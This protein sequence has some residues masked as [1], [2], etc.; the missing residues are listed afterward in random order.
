MA[1]YLQMLDE[2]TRGSRVGYELSLIL[3][4]LDE[5][6]QHEVLMDGKSLFILS[7]G[8]MRPVIYS[9]HI[10]D[11]LINVAAKSVQHHVNYMSPNE[12]LVGWLE[13]DRPD[14]AVQLMEDPQLTPIWSILEPV[15]YCRVPTLVSAKG[16]LVKCST[17]T[18]V[19]HPT[20]IK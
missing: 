6:A 5:G 18:E 8:L 9:E 10:N 20:C 3:D 13:T 15:C 19:F 12:I 4:G 1:A 16:S 14:I 11:E 2:E 17:C 7:I